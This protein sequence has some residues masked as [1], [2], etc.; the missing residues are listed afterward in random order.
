MKK[1]SAILLLAAML[2]VSCGETAGE[3]PPPAQNSETAAAA[4]QTE[5]EAEVTTEV[6]PESFGI[7]AEDFG[8]RNITVITGEHC[9]YEYMI[10]EESGD[11][12]D[13]AVFARNRAVEEQLGVKFSFISSKNWS[14]GDPFYNL[15]RKDVKAGDCSYDIVNGLNCYTSPLIFEGVFQRL[16]TIE[17]IDFSHPW[18][19]PGKSLDGSERVYFSFSDASLSLYK[20]LYV[21]FFNQSIVTDNG[22]EDPYQLVRDGKWTVDAFLSMGS[23]GSSDLNGDGSIDVEND[24]IAYYAKHAANRAFMSA[25]GTS[26]FVTDGDGLPTLNGVSERLVS[27]YEKMQPFLTDKTLTV[28]D[29]EPDMLLLSKSFADGRVLFLVNCIVGVEAMRDMQ[30]DYGII[31]LPK[32]DEAQDTYYSQIATSSSA[33]YLE[34]TAQDTEQLGSVMEAL[35]F[36]SW[37][38]VVPVYYDTALSVKYARDE[39]VQEMLAMVR[40]NAS[41]NIDF[42]YNTIFWTND[43]INAAWEGKEIASWYASVE[44]KALKSLEKY[45]AIELP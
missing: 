37:R 13:D 7:A 1:T 19:V 45:L 43:V 4:E 3:T 34:I 30:D 12:V 25:A 16:D 5:T 33:L 10:E 40:K 39:N 6:T 38:D 35:G 9:S 32:Y 11:V 17:S 2:L 27:L 26:V 28:I 8:G 24:Q 18:W 15:I 44:S 41:T 29:K 36:Y 23:K 14:G 31:P 42:L 20:D 21:M 22:M